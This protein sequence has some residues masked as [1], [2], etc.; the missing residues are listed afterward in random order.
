MSFPCQNLYMQNRLS[1]A[2]LSIQLSPEAAAENV[3]Q[4]GVTRTLRNRRGISDGQSPPKEL[5]RH[6]VHQVVL[7]CNNEFFEAQVSA[8]RA[9]EALRVP[10]LCW[11]DIWSCHLPL[12]VKSALVVQ[13]AS[14]GHVFRL[15]SSSCILNCMWL[16]AEGHGC[17]CIFRCIDI[18]MSCHSHG[19]V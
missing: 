14:P 12:G 6:P 2:E 17:H 10:Y 13:A 3:Q 5:S 18:S 19:Y 7:C 15:S 1:D 9:R 4:E 16:I 8:R 11:L